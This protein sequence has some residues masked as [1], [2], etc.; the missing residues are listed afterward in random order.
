MFEPSELAFR[1]PEAAFSGAL[2]RGKNAV[3]VARH[4]KN[5]GAAG[6][7]AHLAL[8][9]RDPLERRQQPVG[10]GRTLPF[11]GDPGRG[12][13]RVVG[14]RTHLELR[15]AEASSLDELEE[16]AGAPL[17]RVDA[18]GLAQGVG[19]ELQIARELARQAVAVLRCV[20]GGLLVARLEHR[21]ALLDARDGGGKA[22]LDE[23]KL[24]AP[25]FSLGPRP[26]LRGDARH[27]ARV[28][29]D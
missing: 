29:L 10:P 19:D 6:A 17:A 9:A 20:L 8:R 4:R 16:G 5:Q 3:L 26:L 14:D 21:P 1:V 13:P 27:Q 12:G 15:D 23:P 22:G 7:L 2:Q 18:L 25:G 28:L 11:A 24:L